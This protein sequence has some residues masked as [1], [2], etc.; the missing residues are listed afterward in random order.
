MLG[1]NYLKPDPSCHVMRFRG[2]KVVREGVG[3]GMLYFAPTSTIVK[4]PI[5]NFGRTF[6]FKELTSDYQ[7]IYV[8]GR[9]NFKFSDTKSAS[10]SFNL[11]VSHGGDFEDDSVFEEIEEMV[12]SELGVAIKSAV[13]KHDLKTAITDSSTISKDVGNKIEGSKTLE[14]A[15]VS[16]IGLSISVIKAD[17]EMIRALEAN[18][19]ESVQ[20]AADK[21]IFERRNKAIDTE[22]EVQDNEL[23]TK[24]LVTKRN[25]E[26]EKQK[27]SD[28]ILIRKRSQDAELDLERQRQD[29]QIELGKKK[30]DADVINES[31]RT[32]YVEQRAKNDEMEAGVLAAGLKKR[33][34]A[35]NGLDWRVVAAMN[36]SSDMSHSIL[37]D[38]VHDLA[39]NASKINEISITP[40]MLGRLLK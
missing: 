18:V 2:G 7:Q 37:A 22:R 35:L 16:V 10:E 4:V 13:G 14:R 15:G 26:I 34:G 33:V 38:A 32:S 20:M 28:S 23:N 27:Q 3:L 5:T 9:I 31:A 17:P 19:R 36:G 30:T 1:Y 25:A 29:T 40:D 8:G 12:L 39:K 6:N 21:A 24:E 11:S